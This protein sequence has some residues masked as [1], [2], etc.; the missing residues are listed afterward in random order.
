M[1]TVIFC[2]YRGRIAPRPL[3]AANQAQF[4]IDLPAGQIFFFL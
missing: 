2:S 3:N 4:E 1:E